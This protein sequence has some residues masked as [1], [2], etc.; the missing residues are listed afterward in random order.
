[1]KVIVIK[2]DDANHSLYQKIMDLAAREGGKLEIMSS[3]I[4]PTFSFPG[5]VINGK[6]QQVFR[7]GREIRLTRHE[8][9]LLY[10]LAS[11]PGQ[12]ISKELIF[13]AVWGNGSEDTLK[14]VANTVS[15]LRG[16]IEP[17]RQRPIY[18]LTVF[19]GYKFNPGTAAP[20]VP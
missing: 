19:G 9:D 16:K 4:A 12:A 11:Q 3:H 14:V 1:M 10:F 17:C 5:L 13:Q 7:G 2:T 8:Y 18:I 20:A 15:N 6:Q